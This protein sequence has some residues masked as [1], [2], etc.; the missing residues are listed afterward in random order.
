MIVYLG[1]FLVRALGVSG[2][3]IFG[4]SMFFK[5]GLTMLWLYLELCGLCL[6]PLFFWGG[7]GASLSR[8]FYYIVFSGISSSLLLVGILLPESLFFIISGLLVKF[9]VFPFWGW[10]Y[11]V[12]CYSK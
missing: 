11:R 6:I 1:G 12:C 7:A 4:V 3:F 9:G 2:M 10:V 5:L 8:L